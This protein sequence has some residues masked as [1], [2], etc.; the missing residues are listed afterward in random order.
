M[1]IISIVAGV[2]SGASIYLR[3]TL[4][5]VRN[6]SY[7]P[8]G[9]S[10][11]V[12]IASVPYACFVAAAWMVQSR[13]TYVSGTDTCNGCESV[14]LFFCLLNNLHPNL[15]MDCLLLVVMVCF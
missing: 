1:T 5:V 10:V 13:L 9:V 15:V 6:A 11:V 12:M 2:E 7:L 3:V 4:P 8:S 14:I